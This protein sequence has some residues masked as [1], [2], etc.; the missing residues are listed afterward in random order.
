MTA[1]QRWAC[2]RVRT[3]RIGDV[4]YAISD[5]HVTAYRWDDFSEIGR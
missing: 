4:L 5:N 1:R 2:G 3:V